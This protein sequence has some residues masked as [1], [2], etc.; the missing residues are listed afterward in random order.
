MRVQSIEVEVYD[1]VFE[2]FI[3]MI[4]LGTCPIT[5]LCS[6]QVVKRQRACLKASVLY[7]PTKVF[8]NV[9]A[10]VWVESCGKGRIGSSAAILDSKAARKN[11]RQNNNNTNIDAAT[12][13]YGYIVGALGM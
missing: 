1:C 2:S 5:S 3:I 7:C 12:E 9:R 10:Q 8:K 13:C 11:S 4:E 6:Y